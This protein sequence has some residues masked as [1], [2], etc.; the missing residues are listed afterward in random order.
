MNRVVAALTWLKQ[1]KGKFFLSFVSTLVFLF[2]LFPFDDLGD[3]VSTQVSKF[4]H[5]TLFVNFEKLRMS[6]AP[7]GLN[8][9]NIYIETINTPAISA[10]ELT[11][12]PSLS[13]LIRK[14][15]YGSVDADGIFKG[16]VVLKVGSG[17]KTENGVERHRIE[18]KAKTLSL[19]EIR[20]AT[21]LPFAIKGN[22][23]LNSSA[24]ADLTFTEQPD[25]D[26]NIQ[27]SSFE[28]PP[29]NV[30]TQMGPITLPELKLTTLEL[31]G[32]LSAGRFLIESGK[33]GKEGDEL[34]GFIKGSMGL[35]LL[36]TEGG[37]IPQFGSYSFDI[38]LK[39]KK[40]FQDK[41]GPF[42][43]LLD[44]YKTPLADGAQYKLKVSAQN[45]QMPPNMSG[46]NSP[47]L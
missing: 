21:K 20:N 38:D 43:V 16:S 5:N 3:L 28:L 44:N 30:N 12:S 31:K 36:K 10:K 40:S 27:I 14:L 19:A 22:L 41:A 24:L 47:Q 1:N 23:D 29:S 42:M 46:A 34:T 33:I 7:T 15:P 2:I 13:G 32:R 25:I 4:S 6:L 8:F 17:S 9:K 26:M 39:M 35:S 18:I 45:L 37:V 11:I